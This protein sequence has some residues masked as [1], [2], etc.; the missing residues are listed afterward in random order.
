MATLLRQ[1]PLTCSGHS[2]PVVHLHFSQVTPNGSFLIAA[3][4]DGK[5]MLRQGD[6]GDWVGTF[7]GHRGAVWG[8]C[9]NREATVAATGAADFTAKLWDAISGQEKHSF[10]HTHIVKTVDFSYDSS[11]LLTGSMEKLVK[12]F[13]LAKPEAD[14]LKFE[15]H[16]GNLKEV[17]F[18]QDGRRIVSAAEDKTIRMWDVTTGT[19]VKKLDVPSNV[20]GMELS[21]DGEILTVT[22]S[23]TV[24]FYNA[25]TFELLKTHVGP[26]L[27]YSASLHPD[28]QMF[29]FGGENFTMYKYDYNTGVEIESSKGHFGAVHCV[30]FSPDG[31]LYASGSEDGTLRLWQTTVGKTYGLWKC[32]APGE[33]ADAAAAATAIVN[34]NASNGA[35]PQ[36]MKVEA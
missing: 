28:K 31:E 3:S 10:T 7:E 23:N 9:L 6:T 1:T 14:P 34:G 13:D 5:P 24:A 8:A 17:V 30:R 29:V 12:L 11:R 36:E 21:Q 27:L 20:T 2:R 33:T 16:T 35:G 19:E 22:Y 25:D 15:G 18:L 4:K 26:T 32:V